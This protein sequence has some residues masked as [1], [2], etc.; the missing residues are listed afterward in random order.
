MGNADAHD[1]RT[2]D[3]CIVGSGA[4]GSVVAWYCASQGLD[5]LI[6]ERGEF[7]QGRTFDQIMEASEP[8]FA[9]DA[10]G[11]W[12]LTG[13]PWTSCSV[14][15]GTVFYGGA[16]FRLR[17]IDFDASAH[18]GDG[19]LPVTW[20]YDYAD[21]DPYYTTIERTLGVSGDNGIGDPT[22]PGP[23]T[24][25]HLPPVTA[26]YPA[27]RLAEAGRRLG[28]RGF[29][30]PLAVL[31][32][33]VGD[34][35]ACQADAPCMNRQCK[36]DAKGDAWTVFLKELLRQPNVTLLAG[37]AVA[38]LVRR[39]SSKVDHAEVFHTS[40]H[41]ELRRFRARA[42]V[43]A[44]N[45]IQSAA[46]LLRSADRWT[47][48]GLGNSS[49]LVGQGLC[50]KLS[51]NVEG[52]LMDD[53]LPSSSH[54]GPFSTIAFTDY[55]AS[56]DSPAGLGGLIYE[57]RPEIRAPMREAGRVVRVECLLADQ[58][59]RE[60]CVRLSSQSGPIGLPYVVLDYRSHPRDAARLEYLVERAT[61]LLRA[62][63]A[64]YVRRIPTGYEGGSCH[65]HGTVRGGG[66]RVTSVADASGRLHDLDN[67]YI[68]DGGFFPFPGAVNPTLTIQAHALRTAERAVVPFL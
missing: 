56:T 36:Y 12:S 37:H 50:F 65:F 35:S 17:A 68:A 58:P 14:G 3:V 67:L 25:H 9:R 62:T 18:M 24:V 22:F 6:L 51:E 52:Y 34:R 10:K 29:P 48:A 53:R 40:H 5:V 11:C 43:L 33:A 55:Y 26:S 13:Y 44:G 64:S 63:G 59:T 60:N 19:D 21:L 41:R 39:E 38:R 2:Y 57:N 30:T 8:A 4:A 54:N 27:E 45:A 47:K 15:G 32:R 49:G 1:D 66:D 31:T 20:P 7:P 23:T 42:F 16:S 28:L 61:E 46:L